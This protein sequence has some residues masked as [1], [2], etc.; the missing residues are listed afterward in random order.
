[1]GLY[2][3]Y[4]ANMN[5]GVLARRLKRQSASFRRRRGVL[6][7][8]CLAFNKMSSTDAAVGYAN[9][10]ACPGHR[11]EGTLNELDEDALARL[12][13]IELVPRHY[14]RSQLLVH[15][16]LDGELTTAEIY[17][18]HPRWIRPHLMPLRSYL[19][20]LI[21]AADL[22]SEDYARTLRLVPCRD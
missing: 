21:D 2:F 9:V 1:M 4:G 20:H 14:T 10:V 19:S 5:A 8:H 12:D 18:A 7:D 15:D 11:V 6:M 17:I 3:A 13:A 16:S 22:L